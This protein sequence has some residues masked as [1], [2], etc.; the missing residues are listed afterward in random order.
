[1]PLDTFLHPIQFIIFFIFAV[2]E[3]LYFTFGRAYVIFIPIMICVRFAPSPTGH[4]H[5]GAAR[6]AL[7]NW[8]FA[9]HHQGRFILRIEDTDVLRSTEKMSGGIIESLRW[10]GV[11]WDVGPIF[12]SQRLEVYRE[13]AA[14]LVRS[15]AAYHCTCTAE[16][17]SLGRALMREEK[18]YEGTG[19]RC[20]HLDCEEKRRREA[21]GRPY[22]VRFLVPEGETR[23]HDMLHGEIAVNH[24]EIEDFVLLRSDGLPTYHLSVVVDDIAE[25]ITHII[26][27][28]DHISNTPKQILLYR[29]FGVSPPE[30]AHQSLILGADKK[31]LSKRHGV[32]SVLQ[33]RE[34]G[35]LPLALMNYLAQMSWSPGEERIYSQSEMISLF[36]L[37]KKKRGNPVFDMKKLSWFNGQLIS[38]TAAA[39]L[40]PLVREELLRSGMWHPSLEKDRKDWFLKL[41]DLLKERA[42]TLKEFPSRARPFLADEVEYEPEAVQKRLMDPRLPEALEKLRE[43]LRATADFN[44]ASIESVLRARAEKLDMKAALLIHALRVLVLGT[45][46]S[47]GIFFVLELIGREKVLER[48]AH[49]TEIVSSIAKP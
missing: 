5:I 44:A 36:A 11:D 8:L 41:L 7:F 29:A 16:E 23:Y 48:T 24:N 12:Q 40:F 4:L 17:L 21:E 27:G 45:G 26:R 1:M 30:F 22:A 39:E 6:T 32:T 19:C 15:G 13:K 10:L 18:N 35:Y 33:F 9:R 46:V 38:N 25:G 47:P 31:K 42:H 49:L 20:R 14:E 34:D 3:F 43:D 28:D 37:E 2:N